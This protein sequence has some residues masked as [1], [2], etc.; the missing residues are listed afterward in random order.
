MRLPKCIVLS[1]YVFLAF[2]CKKEDSLG[3]D[4]NTFD[5]SPGAG[6]RQL[7]EN[8]RFLE[9]A[10]L[11]D[12][13]IRKH[14]KLNE[15]QTTILYFH[16][17]QMYAFADDYATAV[18]RFKRSTY[19]QE[20]PQLP[21]R[22]NAYVQ[23]TI[24]F[25]NE[26]LDRL[27]ECRKEIAEGPALEGE[28]PNLDVVDRLIRHFG[29]PYSKAYGARR[30]QS[31]QPKPQAGQPEVELNH[32]YVTLQKDTIDAI[33]K[34]AFISE[35]FSMFEQ[36]NI[37]TTTESW[38]G[39][40]L[41]GWRAYLEIFAPGGY[42][43]LTEGS[44]GIGF[45]ASK[46]GSGGAT[47][48][49]LDSLTGEKTLSDLSNWVEGNDSIPWFDNIRLKSLDEGAFSAWLMDFRTDY[50]KYRKIKLTKGGLFD[51][52][53]YNAYGYTTPDKKKAFESKLFDD[54]LEVHLELSTAESA[55]FD[56]FVTALGY[57]A[58]EDRGK[59]SYRAGSFT[60]FVSTLPTPAYRIRKVVC[61]LI[62]AVEPK[63]EYRFGQDARLTVEGRTAVW[64]FGKG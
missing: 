28:K 4:F 25:L 13:Y 26:D 15:S 36:E 38:T 42:E 17:G 27:K 58:S 7:A 49:K 11:I 57:A 19:A 5:Q 34:S 18:D 37:K 16:A 56:K 53:S 3:L 35:Q 59:R 14:K 44:S 48:A 30:S 20:P 54:L 32:V 41:M 51:R 47:K 29:E 45:S 8:G 60:F 12:R 21:L 43:G 40:Y 2:A 1:L 24:A 61:T 39:T 22:W 9:T 6:W 55:S 62:R 23:A 10:A 63:G 52:H 46:L 31:P 64:M 33:A 50:L